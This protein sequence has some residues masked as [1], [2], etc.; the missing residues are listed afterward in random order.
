[1]RVLMR[2]ILG[3]KN[4]TYVKRDSTS[5]AGDKSEFFMVI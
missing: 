1:M 5:Y 4:H 3:E 2:N